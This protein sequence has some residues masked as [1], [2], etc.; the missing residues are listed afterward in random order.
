MDWVYCYDI[1]FNYCW[2]S[3]LIGMECIFFIDDEVKIIGKILCIKVLFFNF[4]LIMFVNYC[5]IY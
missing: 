4:F 2:S 5:I 1:C 3:Y